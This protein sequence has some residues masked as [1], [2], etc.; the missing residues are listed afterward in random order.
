MITLVVFGGL[1]AFL[2]WLMYEEYKWDKEFQ[3]L[4]TLNRRIEEAER[5]LAD[6]IKQNEDGG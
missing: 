6:R 5:E 1:L 4:A 2:C 3:R